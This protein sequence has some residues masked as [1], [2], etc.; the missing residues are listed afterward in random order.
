MLIHATHVSMTNCFYVAQKKGACLLAT[1]FHQTIQVEANSTVY[2]K[3]GQAYKQV[4][5]HEYKY[6]YKRVQMY[7][8]V[9]KLYTNAYA[10]K[11]ELIHVLYLSCIWTQTSN[12]TKQD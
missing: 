11:G 7:L 12:K 4:L 2:F 3:I 8:K 5:I 1:K 9:Y 10:Y 6:M